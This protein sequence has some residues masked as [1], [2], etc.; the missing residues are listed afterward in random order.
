LRHIAVE[1][2]TATVAARRSCS[3]KFVRGKSTVPLAGVVWASPT[4]WSV[5]RTGEADRRRELLDQSAAAQRGKV[6]ATERE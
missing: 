1:L 2:F 4:A 6:C 5:P 3:A